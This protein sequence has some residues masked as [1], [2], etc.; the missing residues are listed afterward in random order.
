MFETKVPN[1]P[2]ETKGIFLLLLD[3][4]YVKRGIHSWER[5]GKHNILELCYLI[6]QGDLSNLSQGLE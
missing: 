3:V 4:A 2:P 1:I 6:S 5:E